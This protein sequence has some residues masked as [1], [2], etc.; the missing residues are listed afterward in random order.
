MERQKRKQ[1]TT[2]AD[3]MR[4]MKQ[5]RLASGETTHNLI[6]ELINEGKLNK[7]EINSQVHYLTVDQNWDIKKIQFESLKSQIEKALEQFP[8]FTVSIHKRKEKKG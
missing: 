2:K 1:N 7:K 3:V 5:Q 8:D 6:K 4:Y